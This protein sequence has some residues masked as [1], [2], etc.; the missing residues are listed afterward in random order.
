MTVKQSV[1]LQ[2]ELSVA[3]QN[4]KKIL[5]AHALAKVHDSALSEDL[6]Q[7][8]F[9][10]TW[11][12]L[13][14]RGKINLM[15]A[16]L[17][18]VLNNLIVDEYRKHKTTSLDAM[19]EKGFEPKTKEPSTIPNFISGKTVIL[20]VNNLPE[21]YKKILEMRYV[22]DLSLKEIHF[23]TKQSKN[24]IAVQVHRGLE[25]LRLLYNRESKNKKNNI[26][27]ESILTAL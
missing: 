19:L 7:Q 13:I 25:K 14:K 3:H 15:K 22:Q 1:R 27:A 12:Y 26:K 6:V 17:F 4:F 2:T 20:L 24:S 5:N 10:K 11:I 23:I 8:A 21:K 16:F 9:M 18:H